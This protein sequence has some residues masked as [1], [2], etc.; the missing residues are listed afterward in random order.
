MTNEIIKLTLESVEA[1]KNSLLEEV[2][3][4]QNELLALP[5]D[6]LEEELGSK[7]TDLWDELDEINPYPYE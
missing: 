4:M 5:E 6:L 1:R 7:Y 3:K 2:R